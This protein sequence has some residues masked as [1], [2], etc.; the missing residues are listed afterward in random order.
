M[1]FFSYSTRPALGSTQPPIHCLLGVLYPA[2]KR[3]GRG[4]DHSPSTSAEVMN[5][6]SYVSTPPIRLCGV[7]LHEAMHTF[8]RR[9]T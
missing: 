1:G 7:V 2:I 9:G 8:S 5:A 3:P 4:A 6:W